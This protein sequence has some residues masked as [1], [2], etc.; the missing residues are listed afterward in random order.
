MSFL[1]IK[2]SAITLLTSLMLVACQ[3][4]S[5]ASSQDDDLN[6]NTSQRAIQEAIATKA[7]LATSTV[8]PDAAEAP[9]Q[10]ITVLALGDS[11]TEGLGVAEKDSYPA[12]LERALHDAG[13]TNVKVVNSGLSGETSTGLVNRLDWVLKTQPDITILTVGAN[14]AMRG[15]EVPTIEQNIRSTIDRLQ[16]EGSTVI[17]GGMQIYDNLGR[18]YVTAFTDM[19]PRIARD[20]GVAFIPFFLNGVAADPELNQDDAIHPTAEGYSHIVKDN[21]MPILEPT[22]VQ[23]IQAKRSQDTHPS[24]K[25]DPSISAPATNTHSE[26]QP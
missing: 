26:T 25:Q 17:L 12:Q 16:S 23:V 21:I 7:G 14:D 15:I 20:T 5:N 9:K 8:N 2:K 1:S 11:L 13:Y 10:S 22:L 24:L 6:K 3:P 19:Y 4:S 18:D